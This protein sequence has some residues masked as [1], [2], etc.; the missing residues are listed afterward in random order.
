MKQFIFTALLALFFLS[1]NSFAA[2]EQAPD[3]D[4][5]CI[6]GNVKLAELKGKVVYLDFWASWCVPCKKSFPW[7]RDIKQ[8]YADKGFEVVA[9][10]LD[11]D[12]KLADAFLKEVDVNFVVAFDESGESASSY[13][14]KG[15]PSSFLIDRD[16][17]LYASHIGFR[18]K[19]KNKLEQAIKELL[20]K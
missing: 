8:S 1:H 19:D 18:E 14:L 17:K 9:V 13:K 3:I 7:L 10:N 16:G 2:F 12:R 5:P 15:M 4:L 20:A 11:K 6:D